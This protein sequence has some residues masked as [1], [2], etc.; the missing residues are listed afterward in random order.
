MATEHD[1]RAAEVARL[2]AIVAEH[3][4]ERERFRLLLSGVTRNGI[5]LGQ[6]EGKERVGYLP[7]EP[8][9][10]ARLARR[11]ER[12]AKFG[13]PAVECGGEPPTRHGCNCLERALDEASASGKRAILKLAASLH[14]SPPPRVEPVRQAEEALVPQEG[15]AG[16]PAG[17][18]SLEGPSADPSARPKAP[19]PPPRVVH[20][21][22]K[23]FDPPHFSEMKF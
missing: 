3:G 4:S 21:R 16:P 17:P 18:E 7:P 13:L 23:W 5:T 20:R 12:R 8:E 1:V 14:W 11:A 10:L 15:A 9:L 6:F 19:E 2:E 22:P